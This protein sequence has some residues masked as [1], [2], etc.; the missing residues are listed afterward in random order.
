MGNKEAK[1]LIAII[2]IVA[3]QMCQNVADRAMQ[4]HGGMGISQDTPIAIIFATARMIRF[5]DGP[6]EGDMSQLGKMTIQA[7]VEN[8]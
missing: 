1:D 5:T 4:A 6:C 2:K 8:L 7:T 3:P